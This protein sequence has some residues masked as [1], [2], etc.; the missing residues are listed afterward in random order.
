MFCTMDVR[1]SKILCHEYYK[2]NKI[3][4]AKDDVWKSRIAA[5]GIAVFHCIQKTAST[6]SDKVCIVLHGHDHELLCLGF[7]TS[8]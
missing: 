6:S 1:Y 8:G 3:L 4:G 7:T 2:P 5:F